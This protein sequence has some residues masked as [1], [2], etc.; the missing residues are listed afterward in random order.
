MV[1]F[2]KICIFRPAIVIA[3]IIFPPYFFGCNQRE[4]HADNNQAANYLKSTSVVSQGDDCEKILQAFYNHQSGIFVE[5][6]GIVEKILKDDLIAPRHQRFIVRLQNG[7]ALLIAHNI[8]LSMRITDLRMGDQVSFQGEYKWSDKGGI[9]HLTHHK[10]RGF[11]GG[12]VKH[13]GIKYD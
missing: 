11:L 8:D 5:S 4:N 12:W 2:K 10:S 9:I 6:Q 13:N 1:S 3:L 7:H